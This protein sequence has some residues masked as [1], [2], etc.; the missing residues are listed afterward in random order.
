MVG[1]RLGSCSSQM[2]TSV[3]GHLPLATS[4]PRPADLLRTVG[5]AGQGYPGS[6]GHTAQEP[7]VC[8]SRSKPSGPFP[9]VSGA[10]L[11]V[12]GTAYRERSGNVSRTCLL[13]C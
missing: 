3:Q 8:E 12:G 7:C 9:L 1:R 5:T 10:F 4:T 11:Q 6:S 2:G 13:V